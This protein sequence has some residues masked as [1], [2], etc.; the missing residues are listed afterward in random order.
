MNQE[1]A[2]SNTGIAA[3]LAYSNMRKFGGD[4]VDKA[5]TSQNWKAG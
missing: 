1:S 4:P 3:K 2:G 5:Q